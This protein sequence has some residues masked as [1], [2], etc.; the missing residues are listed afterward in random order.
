METTRNLYNYRAKC[1]NVVDGDTA[2]MVIDVG[3][4]L[5]TRVRVRFLGINTPER[6]REGY[7]EATEHLESLIL[8]REVIIE[9]YKSDSFG[10]YL[11][12]VYV[13]GKNVNREMIDLG[14][15]VPFMTK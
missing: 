2:D 9:T 6:G 4:Y 5:T 11:G 13:D 1:V 7:S 14:Y 3:F 15:A 10:R 8:D 12:T